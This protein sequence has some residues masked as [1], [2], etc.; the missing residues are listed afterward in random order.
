MELWAQATDLLDLRERYSDLTITETEQAAVADRMKKIARELS[1]R[2]AQI[3]K[4]DAAKEEAEKKKGTSKK[5]D[6]EGGQKKGEKE[7]SKN[8]VDTATT[9]TT[10][11]KRAEPTHDALA[12]A[13]HPA[14]IVS[15]Q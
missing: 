13:L 15:L 11:T 12:D 7:P 5:A 6:K 14:S 10:A 8:K 3:T 4:E 9:T 2:A 1:K